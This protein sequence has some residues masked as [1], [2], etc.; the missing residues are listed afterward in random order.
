MEIAKEQLKNIISEANQLKAVALIYAPS[1]VTDIDAIIADAQS[2]IDDPSVTVDQVNTK[3]V[4]LTG[5]LHTLAVNLLDQ[6]KEQLKQSI[7]ALFLPGDYPSW[8]DA[9]ITPAQIYNDTKSALEALRASDKRSIISSC[10]FT[11]FE[12][13]IK[14]DMTWNISALNNLINTLNASVAAEPYRLDVEMSSL[15]KWDP[16]NATLVVLDPYAEEKLTAGDYQFV[17]AVKIDG[18]DAKQYRLPKA[19]EEALSVSV[20]ATPWTVDLSGIVI[21]ATYSYTYVTSP[22][23]TI[24]KSEDV[25]QIN[26]DQLKTQKIYHNGHFYI[27]RGDHIFDIRGTMVK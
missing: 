4:T 16:I 13:G 26:E 14:V 22:M 18:E 24:S 15:G 8:Y 20:D 2:M 3:A 10:A 7:I 12:N 6:A 11:G 17:T 1:V 5:N 25:E 9:V 19:T 23:F 27:L 21:D